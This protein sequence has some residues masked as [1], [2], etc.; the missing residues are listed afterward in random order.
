MTGETHGL[1]SLT[2]I[3][4]NPSERQAL[5]QAVSPPR[6]AGFAFW[7]RGLAPLHIIGAVDIFTGALLMLG[8][9]L[10]LPM[11]WWPVDV[12]GTAVALMLVLAGVGLLMRHRHAERF[13]LGVSTF[14]LCAGGLLIMALWWTVASLLGLYGAV[15]GGGAIILS[16]VALLLTPY[17]IVFPALQVYVHLR[18]DGRRA[19]R[20]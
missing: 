19:P 9:W 6:R 12:A 14:V 10:A 16:I 5:P 7:A 11:R 3:A 13:A 8:V 2:D 18:S 15:G 20:P 17:L 4:K 1:R